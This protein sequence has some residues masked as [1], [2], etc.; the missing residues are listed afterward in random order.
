MF[1]RVKPVRKLNKN[2]GK[3]TTY[4]YVYEVESY[5]S[6]GKVRQKTVKLLGKYIQ[7]KKQK[8]INFPLEKALQADS[9]EHLLREIFALQLENYDFR[10]IRPQIYKHGEIIANLKTFRVFSEGSNKDVYVNI[11]DKFFGTKTLRKAVKLDFTDL[12][13]FV[14]TIIDSGAVGIEF[15]EFKRIREAGGEPAHD[16]KLLQAIIG[17]FGPVTEDMKEISFEKFKSE[18]GY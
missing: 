7:L 3:S 14:K 16:F 10:Q 17:K 8:Q 6:G 2:T 12:F 4:Y 5:K 18:T 1:L 15:S 9:R 13:E 11:N